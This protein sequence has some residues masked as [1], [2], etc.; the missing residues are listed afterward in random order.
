M[1][2]LR[3]ESLTADE[4]ADVESIDKSNVYRT[5]ERAYD[6]LAVLFFGVDGAKMVELRKREIKAKRERS[7]KNRG[8]WR[9]YL[10]MGKL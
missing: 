6:D 5:L 4:V 9:L 2:Y 3:E 10:R 7:K 8:K 1:M